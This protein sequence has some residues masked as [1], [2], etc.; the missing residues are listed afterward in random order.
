MVRPLL[1]SFFLC[2]AVPCTAQLVTKE[3]LQGQWSLDKIWRTEHHQMVEEYSEPLPDDNLWIVHGDSM[4]AFNYPFSILSHDTYKLDSNR[5]RPNGHFWYD[6]LIQMDSG[7]IVLSMRDGT[8]MRFRRDT[9]SGDTMKVLQTLLRDT[10][11]ATLLT[12][13]YYMVTHF[14][15]NDEE[16]YDSV[17]PVKM[18]NAFSIAD[19]T[20]ALKMIRSGKIYLTANGKMRPFYVTGI[21]WDYSFYAHR[22]EFV[23]VD[24]PILTLSPGEWWT[25][26]PFQV[27]YRADEKEM[28][29]RNR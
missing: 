27:I 16:A 20:A 22:W 11:N 25:G 17:P 28:A 29:S 9:F 13:K 24:V 26:E 6:G 7:R 18:P 4:A 12:E 19:T 8:M 1:L 3:L 10:F 5:F 15:P 14:V 23:S 2:V 21:E